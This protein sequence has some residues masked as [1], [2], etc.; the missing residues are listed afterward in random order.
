MAH[1]SPKTLKAI[2][3]TS[4]KSGF[5]QKTLLGN[6]MKCLFSDSSVKFWKC[7]FLNWTCQPHQV[8]ISSRF[9]RPPN[10][11][12]CVPLYLPSDHQRY[13][14]LVFTFDFLMTTWD[15]LQV[16]GVPKKTWRLLDHLGFL[17]TKSYNTKATFDPCSRR[18][19]SVLR[20]M[21]IIHWEFSTL[22]VVLYFIFGD[23][24]WGFEPCQAAS[25]SSDP[26]FGTGLFVNFFCVATWWPA[27]SSSDLQWMLLDHIVLWDKLMPCRVMLCES[28]HARVHQ[29]NRFYLS[30]RIG[31]VAGVMIWGCAWTI[32]VLEGKKSRDDH[33]LPA[34]LYIYGLYGGFKSW[35]TPRYHPFDFRI[36]HDKPSSY[37]GCPF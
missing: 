11:A 3:L 7:A 9:S 12:Y 15:D 5:G 16:S 37:W 10:V 1:I 30:S 19:D 33:E 28:R 34:G 22:R 32:V 21:H 6:A 2:A 24:S 25:L 14:S 13:W 26:D 8:M 31:G 23:P 35:G 20:A 29:M 4:P 36:F 27:R 17:P 18:C